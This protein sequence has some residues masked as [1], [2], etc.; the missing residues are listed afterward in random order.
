MAKRAKKDTRSFYRDRQA[1][2]MMLTLLVGLIV[3]FLGIAGIRKWYAASLKPVSSSSAPV[4]FVISNGDS[5]KQ[6]STN[7]QTAHLIRSSKAFETYVRANPFDHD[8]QA[9][10]Y[11]LMPSMSVRQIAHKFATGDVA[12]NYVTILPDKRLDEIKQTFAKAGYT[13]AQID[14][15]F[16][17]ATYNGHPALASLPAGASLEGY[18]YPESFQKDASTPAS[19][20][21]KQSLDQMN[22]R[23]T[24][25]LLQAFSAQ[26]LSTFQAITLASIVNEETDDPAYQPTVAQVFLSRLRQNMSLGSDVTAFYGS[27][28]AGKG[29]DVTYDTPYNTRLHPGL[30]PG[31]IGNVTANAL[32]AVA[33]PSGTDY[34]F[35]VAGDDKKIYFARTAAEHEQNI[36]K[37]CQKGCGQ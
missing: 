9:G 10:T 2:A 6:I 1:R 12:R 31:P 32:N 34:L 23:L 19:N 8:L 16:N 11:I 15:A 5:V 25:E 21:V 22:K 17:P 18:L 20:I 13:Q 3:I 27:L 7:L 36:Q 29:K 30:P 24:P 4:S 33:H 26:K 37:Y 28:Q 14:Q 35:F